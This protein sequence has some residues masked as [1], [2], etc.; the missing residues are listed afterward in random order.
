MD[1]KAVSVVVPTYNEVENLRPL[2]QRLFA[3]TRAAGL[4]VEL[5]FADDESSGSD[6]SE[7]IVKDLASEGYKVRMHVRRRHEGRGLSSAVLLGFEL[8]KHNFLVCMDADLQHEP[9]A[10]PS[11]VRPVLAGDAD[12]AI[13]SRNVDRGGIGFEWS[14]SRRIISKGATLLAAPLTS[15]TDPMSGFFCVRRDTL[16][17]GRQSCNPLGFKIALEIMVHCR[18]RVVDVPITFRER[19]AGESK[20]SMKQNFL[21]LRQLLSLYFTAYTYTSLAVVVLLVAIVY[22]VLAALAALLTSDR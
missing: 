1:N 21:Y 17:R 18:P 13:G 9:E 8:A 20:L 5:L 16:N 4:D 14:L 7:N 15:S 11:V 19:H 12:F 10:V 2:T 3:A 6:A 22:A